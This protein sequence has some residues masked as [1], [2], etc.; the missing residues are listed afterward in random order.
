[1]LIKEIDGNVAILK[2]NRPKQANALNK[3]LFLLL[4][5]ELDLLKWDDDIRVVIIAGSEGKAFCAGID[6]KER[7]QKDK[8][9]MLRERETVIRPFYIALGGISQTDNCFFEWPSFWG[10]GGV[11]P[12]L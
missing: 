10:G 5:E 11:S 6:L 4:K 3:E 12:Y 7:A 9:E 8:D 2:L 1:M